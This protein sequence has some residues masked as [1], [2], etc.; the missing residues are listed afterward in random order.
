MA[1]I[2]EIEDV[3]SSLS[4]GPS[5]GSDSSKSGGTDKNSGSHISGPTND[6]HVPTFDFNGYP[7]VS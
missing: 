6:K 5:S 7:Q 3:P 2:F 4:A 1:E